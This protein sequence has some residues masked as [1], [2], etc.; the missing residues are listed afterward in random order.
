MFSRPYRTISFF[1]FLQ[2]GKKNCVVPTVIKKSL[3]VN[4]DIGEGG[5]LLLVLEQLG[6]IVSD[7]LGIVVGGGWGSCCCCWHLTH[8]HAGDVDAVDD[9]GVGGQEV[10]AAAAAAAGVAWASNFQSFLLLCG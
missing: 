9:G 2:L 10:A 4:E 5:Q 8:P 6:Q 3:H 1:L 7:A